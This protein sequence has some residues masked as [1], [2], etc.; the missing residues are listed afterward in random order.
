VINRFLGYWD[1]NPATLI[2]LSPADSAPLYVEMMGGADNIMAKSQKLHD[3]GE[4]F[5]AQE[6]MNKLVQAEPQ[7]Q[8]AKDL[9][10]DIFEPSWFRPNLK[11]RQPRTCWRISSNR[12]VTSRKIPVCATVTCR[13]P[14]SCVRTSRRVRRS[15]RPAPMS[16]VP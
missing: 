10:A 15:T 11:T 1:A 14:W 7:N 4:Y 9:L 5:K 13:A 3:Q 12:L 2:P 6:I 16:F 8:A